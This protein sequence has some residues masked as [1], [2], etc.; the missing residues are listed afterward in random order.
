MVEI[1]GKGI[2][3]TYNKHN[4]FEHIDHLWNVYHTLQNK[5]V[6]NVDSLAA[7]F[8]ATTVLSLWGITKPPHGE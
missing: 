7:S 6:P 2:I 1:T 8:D 4:R 3:K 5:E